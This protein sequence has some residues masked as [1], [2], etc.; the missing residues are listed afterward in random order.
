METSPSTSKVALI[1]GIILL[2]MIAGGVAIWVVKKPEL[3]VPATADLPKIVTADVVDLSNYGGVSKFRSGA[4]H[5]FASGG[6]KCRSM[7][8]YFLPKT[9][10]D[11]AGD[12]SKIPATLDPATNIPIY[13]PVN[14]K[15]TA[16]QTE[17]FPLGKQLHIQV[18]GQK[19]YDVRLFHVYPLDSIKVGSTVKA[20][21]RV[22]SVMS[23][24]QFD[25]AIDLFTVK[26]PQN[27]SY[28]DVMTDD[29]FAKYQA[30]GIK[31]KS[32]LIITKEA[33]DAAPFEC[34]GEEFVNHQSDDA[35]WSYFTGYTPASQYQ[36]TNT[37]NGS[38]QSSQSSA[39]T[40]T[41]SGSSTGTGGGGGNGTGGGQNH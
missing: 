26:G 3:S 36:Q 7:K 5:S 40:S 25:V 20:G 41:G 24:Q 6:E 18:D 15:I 27:I 30:Q 12:P 9:Q 16:I 35:D 2:I 31:T 32:D 23:T 4:G 14:G 29:I 33:R 21:E 19:S 28:F 8:H 39:P 22:G 1:F 37:Q 11:M 38:S 17:Q 10:S 34:K 13:S